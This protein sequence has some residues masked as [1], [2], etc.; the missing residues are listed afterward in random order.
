MVQLISSREHLSNRTTCALGGQNMPQNS[1]LR[2]WVQRCELR[3]TVSQRAGDDNICA[4]SFVQ[5]AASVSYSPVDTGL[6]PS[7]CLSCLAR[8]AASRDSTGEPGGYETRSRAVA[9]ASSESERSRLRR[10]PRSTS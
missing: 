9:K 7:P 4:V 1:S 3:V 10:R 5:P 6:V 2:L 8:D